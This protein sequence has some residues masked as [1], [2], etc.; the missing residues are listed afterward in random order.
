MGFIFARILVLAIVFT[1]F[2]VPGCRGKSL[3]QVD[4]LFNEGVSLRK[5]G[6]YKPEELT[7]GP[8]DA[9]CRRLKAPLL[10]QGEAPRR[11]IELHWTPHSE[12]GL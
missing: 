7:A 2:C 5:F 3:E 9:G 1:W 4:R 8:E 11:K 10:R 6:N 12:A